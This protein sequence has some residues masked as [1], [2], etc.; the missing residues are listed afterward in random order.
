MVV[1]LCAQLLYVCFD[2]SQCTRV[3][4]YLLCE[5]PLHIDGMD[6]EHTLKSRADAG[7]HEEESWYKR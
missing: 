7:K 4:V 1:V 5:D 3:S 6:L 2:A